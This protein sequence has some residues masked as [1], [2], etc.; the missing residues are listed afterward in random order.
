ML[1]LSNYS[2]LISP[3]R[4]RNPDSIIET[5]AGRGQ[6]RAS[7]FMWHPI[8]NAPFDRDLELGVADLHSVRVIPFPCR[9]ILGGWI[10]GRNQ[11]TH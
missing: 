8:S 7:R 2:I 9:R 11:D 6:S 4:R 10:K 5:R 1:N 3:K